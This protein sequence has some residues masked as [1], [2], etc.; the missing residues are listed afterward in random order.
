[1]K[2]NPRI[3]LPKIETVANYQLTLGRPQNS[4]DQVLLAAA[5]AVTA[6]YSHIYDPYTDLWSPGDE[7][8]DEGS[9]REGYSIRLHSFRGDLMNEALLFLW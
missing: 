6:G 9:V 2:P 1:M 8:D 5:A 7:G 4:M 3:N